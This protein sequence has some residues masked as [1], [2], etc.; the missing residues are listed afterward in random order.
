MQGQERE[1]KGSCH[2]M[3]AECGTLLWRSRGM[4]MHCGRSMSHAQSGAS[5]T[6]R[7]N[8]RPRATLS[9]SQ[10]WAQPRP[11]LARHTAAGTHQL[12]CDMSGP[13]T[14][15]CPQSLYTRGS[16]A[17]AAEQQRQ[18][19]A[20]LVKCQPCALCWHEAGS[21]LLHA[22]ASAVRTMFEPYQSRDA[23]PDM[24]CEL[25]ACMCITPHV[26]GEGQAALVH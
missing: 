3:H 26:A 8:P 25:C 16:T 17:W 9:I 6:R 20:S 15:Q 2:L 18:G 12:A 22:L 11:C 10:S 5:S 19:H 7:A 4:C 13:L 1:P 24:K 21:E 14:S 23:T